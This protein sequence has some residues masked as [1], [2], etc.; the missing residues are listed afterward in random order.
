VAAIVTAACLLD[1][2]SSM[3][4]EFLQV[5][6]KT[7]DGSD[8]GSAFIG[9][10]LRQ[11]GAFE[12]GTFGEYLAE[13]CQPYSSLFVQNVIQEDRVWQATR[14]LGIISILSG[15]AAAILCWIFVVTPIPLGCL[16]RG[17]LLPL[18]LI[19]FLAEGLK[20]LFLDVNICNAPLWYTSS[21]RTAC[22]L[23][24]TAYFAIAAGVVFFV[25]PILICCYKPPFREIASSSGRT[26]VSSRL[27]KPTLEEEEDDEECDLSIGNT[28]D[29][30]GDVENSGE[31]EQARES[32][33][34][35]AAK[36]DPEGELLSLQP[37]IRIPIDP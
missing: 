27:D 12:S 15:G 6:V 10:Y 11:T 32:A 8:R 20:F 17:L 9:I 4:C 16:W 1:L 18:L 23:G 19:A 35:T 26:Q 22:E 3:S 33:T 2:Y 14:Y 36:K 29:A 25:C 37:M 31:S 28:G 13:G 7:D 24:T 34:G 30:P 5:S 21:N